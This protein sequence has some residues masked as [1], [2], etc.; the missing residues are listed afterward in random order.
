MAVLGYFQFCVLK[1]RET[2]MMILESL[3]LKKDL[4]GVVFVETDI[5]RRIRRGIF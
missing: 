2:G 5:R 1:F 4:G 3:K